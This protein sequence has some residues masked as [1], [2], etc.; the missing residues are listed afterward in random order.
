MVSLLPL[1]LLAAVFAVV[2]AG[3][4][5]DAAPRKAKKKTIA[6][7]SSVE[8]PV[9]YRDKSAFPPGPVYFGTEYMGEDPDPFIRSQLLRDNAK[10]GAEP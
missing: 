4:I 10:F 7:P 1:K 3:A 2:L 5:A 6:A 9:R 8:A